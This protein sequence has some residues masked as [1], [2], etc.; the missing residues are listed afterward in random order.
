M[1]GEYIAITNGLLL[2]AQCVA[3]FAVFC[4]WCINRGRGGGTGLWPMADCLLCTAEVSIAQQ[5]SALLYPHQVPRQTLLQDG[6]WLAT[7]FDPSDI[8]LCRTFQG[9]LW[10]CNICIVMVHCVA[11]QGH[12]GCCCRA[13]IGIGCIPVRTQCCTH[14][15]VDEVMRHCP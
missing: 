15:S 11:I 1:W 8:L 9:L 7:V 13:R 3:G 10:D 14:F 5:S 4:L 2:A 12:P 6:V